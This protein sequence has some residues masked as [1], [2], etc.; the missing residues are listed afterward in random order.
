MTCPDSEGRVSSQRRRPWESRVK[1]SRRLSEPE[2]KSAVIGD[3]Q[4]PYGAL[5]LLVFFSVVDSE[6]IEA[7]LS[8]SFCSLL[9]S[10]R[11]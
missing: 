5:V 11:Q 1:P 2:T 3:F 6:A 7:I 9:C 8:L 10:A 4:E